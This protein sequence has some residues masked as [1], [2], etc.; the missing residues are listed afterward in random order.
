[1][2]C[3]VLAKLLCGALSEALD[4]DDGDMLE[5]KR[6]AYVQNVGRPPCVLSKH[7]IL[8][9]PRRRPQQHYMHD[10]RKEGGWRGAVECKYHDA[11]D[12]RNACLQWAKNKKKQGSG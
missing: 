12:G 9:W 6:F 3:P 4:W 5:L 1:M 8:A 7:A 10:Q 11:T 2:P